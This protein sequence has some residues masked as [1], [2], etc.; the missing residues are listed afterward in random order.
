[1]TRS[2]EWCDATVSRIWLIPNKPSDNRSKQW[3]CKECHTGY[4]DGELDGT[5]D[6]VSGY[7]RTI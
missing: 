2:C 7:D 4:F 3:V 6:D 5:G 1:M